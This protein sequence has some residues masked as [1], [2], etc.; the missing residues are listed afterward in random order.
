MES[1]AA[2]IIAA[3]RRPLCINEV[4]LDGISEALANVGLWLMDEDGKACPVHRSPVA[5]RHLILGYL[6][7]ISGTSVWVVDTVHPSRCFAMQTGI[8]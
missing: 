6:A 7:A 1:E 4:D 5:T 2:P 3:S 8:G